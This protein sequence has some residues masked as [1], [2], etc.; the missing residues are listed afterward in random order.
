MDH[1]ERVLMAIAREEPDRVPLDLWGSAYSLTDE[2]YFG[3]KQE[4]NIRGDIQPYRRNRLSN[5]YDERVLQALDIDFRHVRLTS[6][7]RLGTR[8]GRDGTFIDA[9]GVVNRLTNQAVV[10]VGHP[11]ADADIDDLETYPWPDLYDAEDEHD[12]LQRARHFRERTD[13]AVVARTPTSLGIIEMCGALRGTEQFLVDLLVD[14]PFAHRLLQQVSEVYK[15]NYTL[16]LREAGRYVDIVQYAADY[17]TQSSLFISPKTYRE[18]LKPYDAEVIA[19]IRE[20]VP[21]AKIMFH[22][23]GAIF[24]LIPDL[25]EIG[26]DILNPLQPMA[27]GMDSRR[28]KANFGDK[29]T[30]HGAIDI[31]HA[32]PGTSEDVRREVEERISALA[33][34]GGYI[35]APANDILPDV[36]AKNVILMYRLAREL[37]RYPLAS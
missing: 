19:W 26:V 1:R 33:P 9:W 4:L 23:C 3:V 10:A 30:F 5:Y 35:L 22:S 6:G 17:G 16:M 14:K 29:L 18:M 21:H 32:L 25:I 15:N 28:I 27:A 13:C 20:L 8:P 24:P 12:F 2:V 34:G 31:Q 36:P 37:G 7:R 11:L